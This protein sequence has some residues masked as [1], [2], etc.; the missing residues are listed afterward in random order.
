MTITTYSFYGI[1]L[2]LAIEKYAESKV[3]GYTRNESMKHG[4]LAF[5]LVITQTTD[6]YEQKNIGFFMLYEP[7]GM[8]YSQIYQ[9]LILAFFQDGP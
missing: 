9:G 5:M 2:I 8:I 4:L 7:E 3:R 1:T 6:I